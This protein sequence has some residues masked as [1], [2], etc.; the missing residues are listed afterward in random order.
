MRTSAMRWLLRGSL[1]R[2]LGTAMVT[3][4][5]LSHS[6]QAEARPGNSREVP[7]RMGS[8]TRIGLERLR[9]ASY[10]IRVDHSEDVGTVHD[11][12]RRRSLLTAS[13]LGLRADVITLQEPSPYQA[14]HLRQD[15]GP[16]WDVE[17]VACDPEAWRTAGSAG[18]DGQTRDGNG[19]AWRKDRL[20]LIAPVDAI[21]LPTDSGFRRTCVVSRFR[22]RRNGTIVVLLSAH[23]DHIGDD[24]IQPTTTTA[25]PAAKDVSATLVV[26]RALLELETADAVALTG[27]MNSFKD[28]DGSCYSS[29][30]SAAHGMLLDVRDAPG[31]LEVD[32]GRGE[33]SWEGWATNAFCRARCPEEP[34]RF[35]QVFVSTNVKVLRTCVPEEKFLGRDG[36]EYASD[37]LPIVSDLL[38]APR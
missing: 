18:P 4:G 3:A 17:V 6:R 10:N 20:S 24:S 1:A 16:E 29:L 22:D 28:R 14:G 23:F 8:A 36:V 2:S 12:Q 7:L 35:D 34:N 21:E 19:V 11:W 5:A 31:C 38:V 13:L 15:L 30:Q 33:S 9:V 32:A 25:R 27:D 26:E 37:H